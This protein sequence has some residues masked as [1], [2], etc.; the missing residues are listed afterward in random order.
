MVLEF[1][2]RAERDSK[3]S[4]KPGLRFLLPSLNN[5]RGNGQRRSNDLT[6]ERRILAT[7]DMPGHTMCRK[8]KC[9]RL[10]PDLEFSVIAHTTSLNFGRSDPTI[11]SPND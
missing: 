2:C 3:V 6:P 10:S 11:F 4:R 5:V 9:V 1:G 8:C 7:T